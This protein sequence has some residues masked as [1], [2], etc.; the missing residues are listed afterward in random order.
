[1]PTSD[2]DL[3]KVERREFRQSVRMQL[4]RIARLKGDGYPTKDAVMLLA[5][6]QEA[7]RLAEEHRDSIKQQLSD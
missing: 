4:A 2:N 7:M 5:E 3:K 1:M 6:F